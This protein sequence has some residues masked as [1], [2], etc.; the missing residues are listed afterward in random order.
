MAAQSHSLALGLCFSNGEA[1]RCRLQVAPA[2]GP[3]G[4]GECFA[5]H[6]GGGGPNI[7]LDLP[8]IIGAVRSGL[9]ALGGEGDDAGESGTEGGDALADADAVQRLARR[10]GAADGA[11]AAAFHDF[12]RGE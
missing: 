6:G 4:E 3:A 10:W 7:L 9:L 1:L 11:N 2:A 12:E 8:A 5:L